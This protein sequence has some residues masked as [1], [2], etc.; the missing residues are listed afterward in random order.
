MDDYIV[1]PK[2]DAKTILDALNAYG[3]AISR[4]KVLDEEERY[5]AL[6]SL[7]LVTLRIKQQT[8]E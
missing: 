4:D 7:M 5:Q 6:T 3:E 1:I 2:D 8:H